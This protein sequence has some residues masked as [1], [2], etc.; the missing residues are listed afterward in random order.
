MAYPWP[1]NP[2]WMPG[3]GWISSREQFQALP[4][5]QKASLVMRADLPRGVFDALPPE[6]QAERQRVS[7][8]GRAAYERYGGYGI[9][10]RK[11]W[12]EAVSA[13]KG[14]LPPITATPQEQYQAQTRQG[15]EQYGPQLSAL[16]APFSLEELYQTRYSPTEQT[17]LRQQF[18][19]PSPF[20]EST[21]RP[22]SSEERNKIGKEADLQRLYEQS[23]WAK[24]DPMEKARRLEEFKQYQQFGYGVS[25]GGF[26]GSGSKYTSPT[27]GQTYKTPAWSYQTPSIPGPLGGA[28]GNLW[29]TAMKWAPGAEGVGA[30]R[31]MAQQRQYENE[32]A[33]AL[34]WQPASIL[35]GE[36]GQAERQQVMSEGWQALKPVLTEM[37][38]PET[39]QG[40]YQYMQEPTWQGTTGGPTRQRLWGT[41]PTSASTTRYTP[42][43]G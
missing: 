21:V 25:G 19:M 30:R 43:W 10:A 40:A 17:M 20:Y 28:A 27:S 14:L 33:N 34:N 15:L 29:R 2:Y 35:G 26:G 18:G 36:Q 39:T 37:F 11:P 5:E 4:D 42:R 24:L 38:A 16:L 22:G 13:A 8:V 32:F 3:V 23:E 41:A 9:G 7:D 1:Q 12:S 31:T 6:M